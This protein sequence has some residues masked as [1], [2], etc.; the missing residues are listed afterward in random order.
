MHARVDYIPLSE[1]MIITPVSEQFL[2]KM[3]GQRSGIFVCACPA[4]VDGAR[5][6]DIIASHSIRL[7]M[8]HR[9]Y[10]EGD[11]Y[12]D[13]IVGP[14]GMSAGIANQLT[15]AFMSRKPDY[16]FF[17]KRI[18]VRVFADMLAAAMS[19]NF[20]AAGHLPA[21]SS[22][23]A[24][25]KMIDIAANRTLLASILNGIFAISYINI[26]CPHCK[27]E[28]AP[29]EMPGELMYTGEVDGAN[30]RQFKGKGCINC[31]GTGYIAYE[32]LC[33][34]LEINSTLREAI[35]HGAGRSALKRLGKNSGT[36][37]FL[38]AAWAFF[39]AGITTID[40]VKRI[41]AETK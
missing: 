20:L 4:E 36:T 2:K 6:L 27:V 40:E 28:L 26:I 21:A 15:R 33:E 34:C 31:A 12:D 23:I 1:D 13:T 7:S 8:G 22:F 10:Y 35:I 3:L 14:Q 19:H 9:L 41:A 11:T 29:A 17:E 5:L 24:L 38:D 18:D 30:L 25:T 16:R 39:R 37:T 32:V